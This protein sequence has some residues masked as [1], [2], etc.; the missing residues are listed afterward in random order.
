MNFVVEKITKSEKRSEYLCEI[1][2]KITKHFFIIAGICCLVCFIVCLKQGYV[3]NF[4]STIY[5]IACFCLIIGLYNYGLKPTSKNKI[6]IPNQI[7][8]LLYYLIKLLKVSEFK[9]IGVRLHKKL[10]FEWL[11]ILFPRKFARISLINFCYQEPLYIKPPDRKID[12][13]LYV[14]FPFAVNSINSS[15]LKRLRDHLEPLIKSMNVVYFSRNLASKL[16]LCVYCT[17]EYILG[18][19][20]IFLLVLF[21]PKPLSSIKPL[22]ILFQALLILLSFIELK[23]WTDNLDFL[24]NKSIPLACRV[25]IPAIGLE[26]DHEDFCRLYKN[27]VEKER[28]GQIVF[29]F[30]SGLYSIFFVNLINVLVR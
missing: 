11:P 21:V 3:N 12:L 29:I 13:E 22:I 9:N 24:T 17:L 14:F 23:K 1:K 25:K 18:S 8:K 15:Q 16:L 2:G 30:L 20:M 28:H 19:M 5:V 6:K 4:C 10:H 27:F 7:E 26:R